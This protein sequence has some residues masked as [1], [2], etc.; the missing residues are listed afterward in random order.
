MAGRF[1]LSV[2]FLLISGFVSAQFP[3]SFRRVELPARDTLFLDSLTIRSETFR[4]FTPKGDTISADFY[5]LNP[6]RGYV[7]PDYSRMRS[8][9][10]LSDSLI[11]EFKVYPFA[12][13]G[14]YQNRKPPPFRGIRVSPDSLYFW[15]FTKPDFAGGNVFRFDGLDKNG[16]LSRGVSFGNTRDLAVNSSFNLQLSGFLGDSVSIRAAI[17]D[18]NIPVQADG[19]TYRLQDFDKVFIEIGYRQHRLTAGD[20][21]VTR[22]NAYFLNV[23]KKAQGLQIKTAFPNSAIFKN[24]KPKGEIRVQAA[25]AISRGKFAVNRF[26]GVEGNQ[27]PYRL[28]GN[29]GETFITILSGTERVY[30]DGELLKRGR[31]NE[32]VIDYNTAEIVFTPARQITRDRRIVVEFEY[33]DRNY[34]RLLYQVNNEWDLGRFKYRLNVFSEQDLRNQPLQQTLTTDQ[35]SLLAAVGDSLGK[36][37][38]PSAVFTDF[39]P[40]EILYALKDTLINGIADSVYV[41]ST[42]PDSARYR[43]FFSFVG[44]GEGRYV[45]TQ[46]TANGRVFRF[47]GTGNGSYEPFTRLIAPEAHRMITFGTEFSMTKNLTAE[48]EVAYSHRDINTFSPLDSRDNGGYAFRVKLN[49]LIP[50]KRKGSEKAD[51]HFRWQVNYEQVERTFSPFVRFR[52]VEFSRD[53][54]LGALRPVG[55]EFIPGLEWEYTRE[56]LGKIS[57]SAQGFMKG[58]DYAALRNQLETRL[59]KKGWVFQTWAS[60]VFSGG[61]GGRFS[62]LRHRTRL[63]KSFKVFTLGLVGEDERNLIRSDTLRRDSYM[64]N[65]W[66]AYISNT[67]SSGIK[68]RVYYRFRLNHRAGQEQLGRADLGHNAGLEFS[69]NRNPAHTLKTLVG[70]RRLQILNAALSAA[71]GDQSALGRIEYTG[72]WAKGAVFWNTYYEIGSGLEN[73]RQYAY[74]PVIN[75]QGTH[76]WDLTLDYNGN[77]VPDLDEFQPAQFNGQGNYIKVFTPSGEYVKTYDTKVNQTLNL[78][79]PTKWGSGNAVQKFFSKFF[80]QN[81]YSLDRK[82]QS[83]RFTD[84]LNPVDSRVADSA[85]ITLNSTLRSS[86]FFNR[87]SGKVGFEFSY[88]E[89]KNKILLTNGI[90]SRQTRSYAAKSRI[91]ISTFLT[92]N[93]ELEAGNR[94]QFSPWLRNRNFDLEYYVAEPRLVFQPGIEWRITAAYQYKS[95]F[96]R[97]KEEQGV[98]TG[99]EKAVLH[100]ASLEGNWN[101]LKK[102]LI[103]GRFSLLHVAF[104]GLTNSALGFEMIEAFAPGINGSWALNVQ[105]NIGQNLQLTVNYDG[106]IGRNLAPVHIGGMQVRA[107]F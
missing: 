67:D 102:G 85:L 82:T 44:Q 84:V 60:A 100:S 20:F 16:S 65:D 57:Y 35:K 105:Y 69:W 87:S 47:V 73:K 30:I 104:N 92:L 91:N 93:V 38:I 72:R 51:D 52:N 6:L 89:L 86:L 26:N 13:S 99:G 25:G 4:L 1:G 101:I 23:Y 50:L 79:F 5:R 53:F 83:N 3:T 10:M 18:E 66:E 36:A 70:Y 97:R 15:T 39:N 7:I 17:T 106:R 94:A 77:G 68:W 37:V 28:T 75:G 34:G 11:V 96:N 54:N 56:G 90:E 98:I 12:F 64:F 103:T 43:V 74:F 46:T 80:W 63:S 78:R 21:Y 45:Q 42:Q 9:G 55:H 48:A 59:A 49:H 95:R 81:I 8:A 33:S 2:F 41:Y 27:G 22:P 32:Y 62:F 24:G 76:Y 31:E 14:V 71:P 61:T 29:E 58:A 107:F 40:D 88:K 19:S